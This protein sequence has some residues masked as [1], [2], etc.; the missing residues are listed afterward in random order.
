[1]SIVYFDG[2]WPLSRVLGIS[3][4]ILSRYWHRMVF[5]CGIG[6]GVELL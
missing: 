4:I 1:M 5:E 6:I 2:G 3:T